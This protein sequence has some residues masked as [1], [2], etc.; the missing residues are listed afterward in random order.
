MRWFAFA[1][2][3]TAVACS[4]PAARRPWQP[5]PI[6]GT[7]A[8]DSDRIARGELDGTITVIARVSLPEHP[9]LPPAFGFVRLAHAD[10]AGALRSPHVVLARARGFQTLSHALWETPV[11]EYAA[12][13]RGFDAVPACPPT[14]IPTLD[15]PASVATYEDAKK[16]IARRRGAHR[17][18]SGCAR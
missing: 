6:T 8:V 14:P 18:S 3:A 7:L 11:A 16:H 17:R 5:S 12:A 9:E 4:G 10:L 13:R 1:I 15:H 2:L